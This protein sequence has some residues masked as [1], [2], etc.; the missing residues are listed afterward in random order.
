[1]ICSV[2]VCTYSLAAGGVQ[3]LGFSGAGKLAVASAAQMDV[4][5]E[6]QSAI[7]SALLRKVERVFIELPSRNNKIFESGFQGSW[8]LTPQPERNLNDSRYAR[9]ELEVS[10]PSGY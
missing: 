6:I 9:G 3:F 2:S 10:M 4:E 8:T 1:M 7:A 5:L